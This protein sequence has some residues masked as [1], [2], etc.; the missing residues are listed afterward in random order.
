[1]ARLPR[2]TISFPF[3]PALIYARRIAA[4]HAKYCGTNKRW[5]ASG[6]EA[7]AFVARA[8]TALLAEGRTATVR[9]DCRPVTL[10]TPALDAEIPAAA[11]AI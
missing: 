6:A 5:S 11:P 2:V 9:L 7:A 8:S 4:P 10:G 1:M 3:D